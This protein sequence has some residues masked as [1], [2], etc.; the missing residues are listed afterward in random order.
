MDKTKVKKILVIGLS[1]I[2]DAVLTTPVIQALRENFPRA[3]LAVLAGPRAF[4]VFKSDPRIDAKIVYDKSICWKNKLSLLNRLRQDRYDL[5]VD[6]R[7]S[8][9]S[10]ILG[11]K[12]H[13]SVFARP[14]KPL[15][16]MK[17]RH[18][19][20]LK[21]LGLDIGHTAGPSVMFSG[22]ERN[23][24]NR[25]FDKWQIKDGQLIVAIAPGARNMTKR[26]EKE[27]YRQLAG[28]LT[29]EYNAKIIMVGDRQDALL[30]Q[31]I[32]S[33]I[34]PA[35][36]NAAGKTSIGELA[37]LLTKC[38]L[39]VSC[40]SAPMHLGWAVNTPVVA[41]FGPTSHKKY[42]PAG[43]DDIVLRRDLTCSPCEQSLCPKGTR[44]CMKLIGAEEVFQACKKI[45][46]ERK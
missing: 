30:A 39:L 41:I 25:L 9:F 12:Y 31:E 28:R 24:V 32:I 7:S 23:Y 37:F 13:T 10:I 40:D 33:R 26:W 35:P 16:H 17:D 3:H 43:P 6:L 18:L 46:D 21:S 4:S 15:I 20:K 45:L 5:V 36:L 2:G 14:P 38:R 19:W 8:A 34:E 11:A 22:E 42:A 1:N 44:Q 27:G 29:K